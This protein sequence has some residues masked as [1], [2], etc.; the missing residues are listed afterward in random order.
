[1]QIVTLKA[2]NHKTKTGSKGD[3]ESVGILIDNKQGEETW[4]NGFGSAQTKS[5]NKGDRVAVNIFQKGEYWNFTPV[6]SD[7]LLVEILEKLSVT[8]VAK[9]LG[10]EIQ[11]DDIPW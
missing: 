1:M 6:S 3:F 10:G 4:I 5:W 9:A 11:A 2:I 8:Q 7:A